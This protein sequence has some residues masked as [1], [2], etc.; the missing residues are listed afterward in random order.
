MILC[1]I[2]F[3]DK[4]PLRLECLSTPQRTKRTF[5]SPLSLG[6]TLAL[7]P[8]LSQSRRSYCSPSAMPAQSFT[9]H[10]PLFDD[11]STSPPGFHYNRLALR[12][13]WL[14]DNGVDLPILPR[15]CD[16]STGGFCVGAHKV[17]RTSNAVAS[18]TRIFGVPL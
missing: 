7:S 10:A 15:L 6:H 11:P 13:V 4:R 2:G 1:N 9:S 3:H 14:R 12:T 5:N 17:R 18:R 16:R 8:S